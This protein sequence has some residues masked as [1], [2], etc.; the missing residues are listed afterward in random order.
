MVEGFAPLSLG[1]AMR[2]RPCRHQSRP[3]LQAHTLAH[4]QSH[5]LEQ[6][7]DKDRRS[8]AVNSKQSTERPSLTHQ[9]DAP[10]PP[11]TID[12]RP[13]RQIILQM[14]H[15]LGGWSARTSGPQGWSRLLRNYVW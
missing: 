2:D 14:T 8:G 15:T 11:T 1:V 5:A 10:G 6:Q 9:V 4:M 12:R 3:H 13:C 7:S